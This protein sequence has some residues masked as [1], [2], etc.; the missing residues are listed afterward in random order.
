MSDP[1]TGSGV[2]SSKGCALLVGLFLIAMLMIAAT[3]PIWDRVESRGP[4]KRWR[5]LRQISVALGQYHWEKKSL[6]YDPRGPDFALYLLAPYISAASF[7]SH[8]Y[9]DPRPEAKWDHV[10]KRLL[11]SDFRYLNPP[12]TEACNDSTVICVEDPN[13]LPE[14]A[15]FLQLDRDIQFCRPPDDSMRELLGSV[16]SSDRFFIKTRDVLREWE[17]IPLP[18]DEEH[19]RTSSAPAL[20]ALWNSRII[21][22][23]IGS[24]QIRYEYQNDKLT[25]RRFVAPEGKITDTVETDEIGQIVSFKREPPDWKS[26]WPVSVE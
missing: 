1:E 17:S 3:P 26:F 11:N 10:Q 20:G 22:R 2:L 12:D 13:E 18:A 23:R 7:D 25:H 9:D 8:P 21:L 16:I 4:S 15:L 6:P 19:E 24:I 14:N 5:N